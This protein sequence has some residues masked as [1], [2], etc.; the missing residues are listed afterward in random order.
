MF[1]RD[2]EVIV[3]EALEFERKEIEV[4]RGVQVLGISEVGDRSRS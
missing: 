1:G 4:D 3:P 2:E